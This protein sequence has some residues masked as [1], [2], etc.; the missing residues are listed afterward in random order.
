MVVVPFVVFTAYGAWILLEKIVNFKYLLLRVGVLTGA[1]GFILYSCLLYFLSYFIR[2]PIEDARDWRSEDKQTVKYIMD[3]QKN[4]NHI[5][6]D[7]SA[8]F[9]YTSLLFYGKY[10]PSLHQQSSHYSPNGLVN[11]LDYTGKFEFRKVDWNKELQTPGSLYI[12]GK[13]NVPSHGDPLAVISYPTHPVVL[14]YDRTIAQFPT[15]DV[16]YVI[17]RSGK[18]N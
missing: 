14:Y 13:S 3:I 2:M 15:T 4:Y 5:V 10:P 16:A 8:E 1:T 6:F 17:V 18:Q 12:T 7:D 11:K 9:F